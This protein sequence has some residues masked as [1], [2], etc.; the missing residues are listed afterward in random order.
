MALTK[1]QEKEL[2]MA[3][4][5]ML[6]FPLGVMRM[7]RIRNVHFRGTVQKSVEVGATGQEVDE[8]NQRGGHAVM[9]EDRENGDRCSVVVIPNSEKP[10]EEEV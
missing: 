8:E 7:D 3:E 10:K 4:L 2:E 1:R 6:H 9:G 5:K